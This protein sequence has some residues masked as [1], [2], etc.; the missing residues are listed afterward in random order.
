MADWQMKII[1]AEAERLIELAAEDAGLR[2][3]LKALAQ[4]I[5]AATAGPQADDRAGLANPASDVAPAAAVPKEFP[6]ALVI[7]ADPRPAA[8]PLRELTLG[9]ASPTERETRPSTARITGPETR[10]DE[11]AQIEA[12][13]RRKA[14]AARWA[15]ERQRRLRQ[16]YD[17]QAENL[18]PDPEIAKWA[19][20]LT[21]GFYWLNASDASRPADLSLLDDVGGCFEVVAEALS[22]VRGIAD[23]PKVLEHV[24]PLI[25]EAQSALWAGI[26]R[27]AAADDTDQGQVF[28]WLKTTAARHRV[29][30]KRFMRVDDPADPTRWP[31]LLTRIEKLEERHG[32]TGRQSQHDRLLAT[33]SSTAESSVSHEPTAEVKAVARLLGGRSVVLIGG[34]RRPLAQESLESAFGLK[35]LIWIETKEHQAVGGF[36][37]LIAR[38]DVALVLLAIRWSS[39]AFGDVK[40]LCDRHDT[41]LVR[42]PGG[43]NPNQVAAQVLSQCSGQ[44]V[45]I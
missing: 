27:V 34:S 33:R 42:L 7:P 37:P 45:R 22:L 1:A 16:G 30:I 23:N 29:Y 15:A 43:Y 3:D 9:R 41:P 28:E 14:E 5:L 19:D 4:K 24:L 12:S 38:R 40:L 36:E 17:P 21:D 26:R 35:E 20:R 10:D 6:A 31:E 39:H 18:A 8:E 44:L 13:C 32:P 25:A 2:G 11:I